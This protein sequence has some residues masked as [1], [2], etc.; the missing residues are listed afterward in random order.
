MAF[1]KTPL[2][3]AA[4]IVLSAPLC[5]WAGGGDQTGGVGPSGS[6]EKAGSQTLGAGSNAST[7]ST[8]TKTPHGEGASMVRPDATGSQTLPAR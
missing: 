3:V 8:K 5:A 4:V 6:K 2:C 1:L 7:G